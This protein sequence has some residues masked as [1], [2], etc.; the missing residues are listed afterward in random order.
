MIRKVLAELARYG[1]DDPLI[2]SGQLVVAGTRLFWAISDLALLDVLRGQLAARPLVILP[3]G[4]IVAD[5]RAKVA[6]LM[7]A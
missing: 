6:A 4:E 5:T 2:Q 3:V 1:I 7:A